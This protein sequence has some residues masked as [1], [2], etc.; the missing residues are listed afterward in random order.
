MRRLPDNVTVYVGGTKWRGEAPAEHCPAP[1]VAPARKAR[2]VAPVEE[3]TTTT[4]E[5]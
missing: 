3:L 4:E 1:V 2:Q 5:Q